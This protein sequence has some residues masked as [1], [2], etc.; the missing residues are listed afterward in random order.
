MYLNVFLK[1]KD[2]VNYI[3]LFR[4]NPDMPCV[5]RANDL[6]G[7]SNQLVQEV[8]DEFER[9]QKV[10]AEKTEDELLTP[11]AV[12]N[13]AKISRA[14]LHRIAKAGSLVPLWVGGQRRY[15][16]MDLDKYLQK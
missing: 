11:A 16:R 4:E 2:Y 13:I 8:R 7:F 14:T 1:M 3:D 12:M 15:R 5:L 6:L 10:L 9:E